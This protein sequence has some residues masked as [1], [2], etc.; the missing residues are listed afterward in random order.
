MPAGTA[1]WR[2]VAIS[3]P[4]TSTEAAMPVSTC[5]SAS[6]TWPARRP[7]PSCRQ[8]GRHRPHGTPALLRRPQ[9]DRDHGEQVIQPEQRMAQTADETGHRMAAGMRGCAAREQAEGSQD[10][11]SC[12]LH[13]FI[14]CSPE[15]KMRPTGGLLD[16]HLHQFLAVRVG[17][18]HRAGD[19]GV[20]GVDGAQ[21]L[22]RLFR[23]VPSRGCPAAPLRRRR[24]GPARRADRRSRCWAPRPGSC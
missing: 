6:P 21:D 19:A 14:A 22:D 20:E 11:R 17:H 24:A 1:H 15:F 13:V 16:L 8:S 23:V 10:D 2:R 7:A 5:G 3:R 12:R 18:V 9:T 4:S